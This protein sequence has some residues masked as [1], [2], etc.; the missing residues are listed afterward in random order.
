M[1]RTA[2]NSL[3]DDRGRLPTVGD[4]V[5]AILEAPRHAKPMALVLRV[6]RRGAG[7]QTDDRRRRLT[8]STGGR[9]REDAVQPEGDDELASG[10]DG[11]VAWSYS[12]SGT[13]RAD[14]PTSGT[15]VPPALRDLDTTLSALCLYR[16]ALGDAPALVLGRACTALRGSIEP[17]LLTDVSP[18]TLP[19]SWEAAVDLE[20]GMV[21]RYESVDAHGGATTWAIEDLDTAVDVTGD[22][23]AA[24]E[25]RP[26]SFAMRTV[27]EADLAA[28]PF[29]VYLPQRLPPGTCLHWAH[30][31]ERDDDQFVSV[32]Y[33]ASGAHSLWVH[34]GTPTSE[35]DPGEGWTRVTSLD[36]AWLVDRGNVH[37]GRRL[38]RGV[39]LRAGTVVSIAT[40]FDE[41]ELIT[42]LA[43]LAPVG[44][45]AR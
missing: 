16:L 15:P 36:D 22:M 3:T 33:T 40:T 19:V 45:A 6:E 44:G 7:G 43:S 14:A 34:I 41:D 20:T 42:L 4:V 37:G 11:N 25:G 12:R 38:R 30:V 1:E 5:E 18:P 35:D 21:M 2:G 8:I 26:A 13:K 24:P 39:A 27:N 32:E 29:A 28:L 23:L 9:Y 17:G 31:I 10:Y